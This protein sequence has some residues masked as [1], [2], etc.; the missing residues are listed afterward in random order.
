MHIACKLGL[1]LV[2][3][4]VEVTVPL[5]SYHMRTAGRGDTREEMMSLLVFKQTAPRKDVLVA[6]LPQPLLARVLLRTA[7]SFDSLA[8]LF[9]IS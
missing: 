8:S 5:F 7:R 2:V 1:H 9:C 6:Q 3:R 4:I